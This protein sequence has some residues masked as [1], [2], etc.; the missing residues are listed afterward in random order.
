[1]SNTI[2]DNN[3]R[4]VTPGPDI[5]CPNVEYLEKNNKRIKKLIASGIRLIIISLILAVVAIPLGLLLDSLLFQSQ[6]EA[7]EAA[8]EYVRGHGG[9]ALFTFGGAFLSF[10]VA[11][12]IFITGLIKLITGCIK[13]SQKTF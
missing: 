3:S 2:P 13:K 6:A 7:M 11:P 12:I 5:P 1:M 10:L 4:Q 9:P 8:G